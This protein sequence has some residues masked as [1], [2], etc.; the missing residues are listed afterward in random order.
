MKYTDE[1]IN[2]ASI[3]IEE[4]KSKLS[5]MNT[6]EQIDYLA[7]DEVLC[8]EFYRTDDEIYIRRVLTV[9]LLANNVC[10]EGESK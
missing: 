6:K 9:L 3:R 10:I 4:I 1:K 8:N 5:G 2:Y 7:S